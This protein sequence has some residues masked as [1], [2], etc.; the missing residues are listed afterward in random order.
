MDYPKFFYPKNSLNLY[1]FKKEFNFLTSLY[2]SNKLPKVLMLTG[3]R[4]SGKSTLINHFL[5]YI[6]D[7]INYDKNSSSLLNSSILYNQFIKDIFQNI[8]YLEGSDFKSIKIEDIRNLKLKIQQSSIMNKD[9]FI[10][11]NDVELFNINSLNALLKIIEEPNKT[12]HFI[13]INNKSKPLIDTIK[14]RSLEYKIILSENKKKEIIDQLVKLHNIQKVLDPKLSKLTPGNFLK[15]NY[16][17][18]E[19]NISV[20]NKFLENLSLLINLY[21][22]YKDIL[23]FDIIFY[24]VDLYFNKLKNENIFDSER[25][26][27]TKSFILEN[28]NK[29]LTFNLSQNSLINAINNKL[30]NE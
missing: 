12:D 7:K 26:F 13:L 16:I 27:E 24:L 4:G 5:F 3:P 11:L 6:F 18:N 22:K 20:D 10:I 21:K 17:F 9:R 8:I 28:L 1:G 2:S 19:L 25:I 30:N 14:S 23:Y 29:Y 15:Y